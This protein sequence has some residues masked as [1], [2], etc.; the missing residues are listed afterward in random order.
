MS[1][2][3]RS[4]EEFLYRGGGLKQGAK[5]VISAYET[6]GY[7]HSTALVDNFILAIHSTPFEPFSDVCVGIEVHVSSSAVHWRLVRVL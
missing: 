5:T 1:I 7:R 3:G 4:R 6:V 2:F